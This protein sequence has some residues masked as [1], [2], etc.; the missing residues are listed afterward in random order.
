M[1]LEH[2]SEQDIEF[3]RLP[4]HIL[5]ADAQATKCALF[6]LILSASQ[7]RLA[8]DMGEVE[9]IDSSGLAMLVKC[10]K[11]CRRRSGDVCLFGMQNTTR[12][13]F[14]LTRLYRIL[15]IADHRQDAVAMFSP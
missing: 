13:L 14:R 5:M 1:H 4:R 7:P 11:I 8:I 12:A 2:T 10:L 15:P 3:V 6:G 9:F